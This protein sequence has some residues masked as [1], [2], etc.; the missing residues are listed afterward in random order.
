MPT[1]NIYYKNEKDHAAL[2]PIVRNLKQYI[3]DKLTCN[4][5][6][7]SPEEISVRLLSVD[8]DGMMGNVDLEIAAHEFPERVDKQD[9]ICRD[10]AAYV[11]KEAPSVGDVKVWLKLCQLGHSV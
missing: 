1:V 6:K 8:G 5:I 10:A 9:E 2:K 4:D 3:A 11:R 7:L